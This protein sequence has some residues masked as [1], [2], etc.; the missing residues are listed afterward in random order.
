MG[1]RTNIVA[2]VPLAA[3]TNAAAA[4]GQDLAG[5]LQLVS[6]KIADTIMAI[7]AVEDFMP[8]GTTLTSLQT[9]VTSLT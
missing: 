3:E 2:I 6:T 9:A 8:A 1:V 7:T 5:M 4:A